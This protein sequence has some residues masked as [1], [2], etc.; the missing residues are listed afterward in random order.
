LF[1]N[2]LKVDISENLRFFRTDVV[3]VVVLSGFAM[4]A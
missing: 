1:L 4:I 3:S 2:V